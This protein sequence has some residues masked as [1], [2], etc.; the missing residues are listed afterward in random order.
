MSS[1]DRDQRLATKLRENLRRRKA[2][3]K[4]RNAP[5]PDSTLQGKEGAKGKAPSGESRD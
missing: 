4:A 2:Q 5:G 1:Q 3:A